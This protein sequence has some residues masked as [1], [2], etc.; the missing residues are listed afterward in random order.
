[1]FIG[2]IALLAF[3]G[4]VHAGSALGLLSF[5]DTGIDVLEDED[6]EVFID[7]QGNVITPSGSD[8]PVPQ[9]GD[10]LV[11]MWNVQLVKYLP[12]G[13]S[14]LP[15]TNTFTAL[16]AVKVG[17]RPIAS[18]RN[19]DSVNDTFVLSFVPLVKADWDNLITNW[20]YL[21]AAARPTNEGAS[22]AT[23]YDDG[24]KNGTTWINSDV[25]GD[26]QGSAD[27]A[28]DFATAIGTPLWEF[29]FTGAGGT[30]QN[31]EFWG[32]MVEQPAA[33][34][35]PPTIPPFIDPG[36]V[37]FNAAL[38]VTHT[39]AAVGGIKLL[40]HDW[41]GFGG[42]GPANPLFG[43]TWQLQLNGNIDDPNLVGDRMLSTDTNIYI[44]PIPEPGSLA[45]IG[46]GLIAVGTVA[47]RRRRT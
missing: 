23:L 39:Y 44:R 14:K 18:D 2:C 21:P 15:T 13:N 6:F 38:N 5:S 32:A 10:F 36:G 43:K 27:W 42:G 1:V 33:I 34:L 4:G 37:V 41:L 40:P 7:S 8:F 30:P 45:L 3:A 17:S 20:G 19:N 24:T 26:Q 35:P 22:F 11:S 29:G 12:S 25:D 16:A 46:L 9:V 31:G 28:V 47:R